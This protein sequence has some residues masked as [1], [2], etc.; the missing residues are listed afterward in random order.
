MLKFIKQAFV[1][2]LSFS[3]SLAC[4]TKI[5]GCSKCI[6]LN[7]ELCLS[8][9]SPTELNPNELHHYQFIVSLDRSNGSCD[10]FDDLAS[11]IC[12]PN[13]TKDVNLNIFNM[14]TGWIKWIKSFNNCKL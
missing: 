5:S 1:G 4:A 13:K 11:R 6:S 10:A 8:K 9:T 2:L 14:I 3:G 12:V 7:I